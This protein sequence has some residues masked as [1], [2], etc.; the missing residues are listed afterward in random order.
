MQPLAPDG[1]AVGS[2]RACRIWVQNLS[3]EPTT[4]L[5]GRISPGAS[6]DDFCLLL[7]LLLFKHS[8]GENSPQVVITFI[9]Q[10]R[11]NSSL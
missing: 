9:S 1:R 7:L 4:C 11:V 2:Q 3:V 10:C 8:L 5:S 6:P